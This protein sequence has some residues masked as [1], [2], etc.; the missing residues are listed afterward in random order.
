MARA[1]RDYKAAISALDLVF[2]LSQ[3][4]GSDNANSGQDAPTGRGQ[5]AKA[6]QAAM[7]QLPDRFNLRD[8]IA[9]LEK[10]CSNPSKPASVCSFL[11]RQVQAGMLREVERGAG[12]RPSVYAKINAI[13]VTTKT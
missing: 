5:L 2:R 7:E 13:E 9:T 8:V 11:R 6:I 1:R 12:R 4:N 3:Q 10:D